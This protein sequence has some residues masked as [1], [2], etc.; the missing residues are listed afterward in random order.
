MMT[1]IELD[2]N[3]L[4]TLELSPDEYIYLHCLYHGINDFDIYV[5]YPLEEKGYIKISED[6]SIVMRNK[7]IDLFKTD[8]LPSKQKDL[9]SFVEKYRELFPQG[10]KSGGRLVKG[11]KQGC[12]NK[13][14]AFKLKYPEYSQ[15]EILD[16]A[17]AYVDNKRKTN[18]DRMISADYLISKDGVSQLAA[19]LEDIKIRG[20]KQEKNTSTGST[21][22]I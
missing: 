22:E 1:K 15:E 18:Y 11:D 6:N 19:Y 7:T 9:E 3:L 5:K 12:I 10:V 21:K 17:K 2:L 8:K 13:F 14:K 16:A 20:K 4:K